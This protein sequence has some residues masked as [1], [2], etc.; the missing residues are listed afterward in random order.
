MD[1]S[2]RIQGSEMNIVV[3]PMEGPPM[4]DREVEIVERKGIGHP[5]TICDGVMEAVSVALNRAYLERFGTV[6]H[7]NIDKG[8]LIA[9]QVEKWFGGGQVTKPMELVIGDRATWS[10]AGQE[11]PVHD[12][13]VTAARDWF[14]CNLPNL[15]E[16]DVQI[17]IALA[18]ASAELAG[19]FARPE[20]IHAANDTSA[21]VGYWPRTPTEAAVLELEQLL[22]S[23][24]FKERFPE[25]GEDVKV[26]GVRSGRALD[27]TVAMPLLCS[28]I[29]S[30]EEY[31]TR[32]AAIQREI[33]E[34]SENCVPFDTAVYLNALDRPGQ[35]LGGVYLTLLGTSAED[36]DSGQV[37]RGNRVNGLIAV[38]RPIGTEAA[39]GKNP[40]SHVGKI[41]SVLTFRAARAIGERLIG[42]KEVEVSLVSRIGQ[43]ID[44][45]AL[46]SV[47]LRAD[48][49]VD[50][51]RLCRQAEAVME[52]ELGGV[53]D[54]CHELARGK[55]AVF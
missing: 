37:G 40:Y 32:K 46:A 16:S 9:G 2:L 55:I 21:A 13:A 44:Q 54:L 50:F 52:E 11:M 42:V 36:A 17:R 35:G 51:S 8:M 38:N 12:I 23:R 30:E 1:L 33:L 27:L 41:Y 19:I 28:H 26:M 10:F 25:T 24:E 34:W 48:A 20:D 49:D 47:R 5:D 29:A 31:F 45:P 7:N 43:P 22:N 4:V 3:E 14:R 18:P 6:L 53:A 15:Q 39:A